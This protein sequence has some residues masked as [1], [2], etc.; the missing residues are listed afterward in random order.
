MT[1]GTLQEL[2]ERLERFGGRPA[3]GL[4]RSYGTRWW[5]YRRLHLESLRLAALL[6]AHG[7]GRGD[8]V[9]L[10]GTNSPEWVAAGLGAILR[11]AVVVPID[12]GASPT[13]AAEIVALAEARLV[14]HDPDIDAGGLDVHRLALDF[15]APLDTDAV[16]VSTL[17][18]RVAPHETAFLLFT[19]GSTRHPHGVVLTHANLVVQTNAFGAWRRLTRWHAFRLLALSPLS[20]VQG[21][22]MGLLVPLSIGISVVYSESIEPAHV[23]RTL[24]QNR[25]HILLAV[26]RVQGMLA[27]ALRNAPYRRSGRT[28]AARAREI[29]FFPL[30]RHVLF[31]ATRRQLGYSFGVLLVGG[32][33]LPSDDERFWYECGYVLVQGYGLTETSALVSVRTNGPFRARLGSVGRPLPHQDVRIGGDGEVLVRGP[34]VAAQAVE[35]DYLHTGDLGRLDEDG[36]LWLRGR[37]DDVIVTAE[38]LTVDAGDVESSLRAVAGVREAVVADPWRSGQVHAVLLLDGGIAAEDAVG[39]ANATLEPFQR[40]HSWSVWPAADFPRTSL[41]KVRRAAIVETLAHNG[42]RPAPP[43]ASTDTPPNLDTIR[44][45]GDRRCRLQ[46]LARYLADP[47]QD[48]DAEAGTRIEDFGLSSLDMVELVSLLEERRRRP[49]SGSAVVPETTIADLRR[50]L[51]G[52]R[53]DARPALPT[54]QPRWSGAVWG[55]AVRSVTHPLLVDGWAHLMA[56]VSPGQPPRRPPSPCIFA[57]APHRHWLDAFAVQAALPSGIRTITVTNRDFAEHFAPAA[58]TPRRTQLSIGVAYNVLWPLVFEFAIVPNF[59]STREGL[60]ELGRAIG[61]GLS[62]I[63]FPKG[64]APPGSPNPRHEAGIASLATQTETPVVPVWLEGNDELRVLS[65]GRRPRV[66]V[67]FGDPIPVGWRTAPAE[68]VDRVELAYEALAANAGGIR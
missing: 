15:G 48:V 46:L 31:L 29:G 66:R 5:S 13:R 43:D 27:D 55:R 68:I 11:G 49:L 58:G 47:E 63:S 8:R 34:N 17:V 20:H 28:L 33:T 37:K 60:Q 41:L 39:A 65:H 7:V 25:I 38:G 2:V 57:V 19:S 32:A 16:D 45:E 1:G 4:R 56:D 62:P 67:H 52:A 54:H 36:R 40:V 35:G 18:V 21:L 6:A 12:A 53:A 23:M 30:R 26:P 61:R 10:W 9:A 24:R 14:L 59:G 22:L 51:S 44:V 3:L 42:R 50:S 64:L